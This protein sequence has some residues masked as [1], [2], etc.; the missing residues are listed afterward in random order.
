MGEKRIKSKSLYFQ[1][2]GGKEDEK[3]ELLEN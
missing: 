3:L 2:K 1:I